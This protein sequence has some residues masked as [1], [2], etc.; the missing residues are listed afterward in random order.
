MNIPQ[1]K[2]SYPLKE[3]KQLISANH[4]LIQPNALVDAWNVFGWRPDDIKKCLLKL[5]DKYYS[6]NTEKNHFH[7]TE[8]HRQFSGTML[9][10]YK[11]KNIMENNSVYTHFYID[12]DSGILIINSFKEL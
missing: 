9:D 3:V 12:T 5:N 11:A 8:A 7:K 6:H 1:R 2:P 4:V 10:Y